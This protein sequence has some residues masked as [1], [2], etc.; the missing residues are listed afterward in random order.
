[1]T[2][3]HT[4]A[5]IT[6][7]KKEEDSLF[8]LLRLLLSPERASC[9]TKRNSS[10]D[11]QR[12]ERCTWMYATTRLTLGQLGLSSAGLAEDGRARSTLNDGRGVREDG[13]DLETTRAL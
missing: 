8:S 7:L 3:G 10:L 6:A 1:M 13:G 12:F 2:S 5:I 9:E 4:K 11:Q